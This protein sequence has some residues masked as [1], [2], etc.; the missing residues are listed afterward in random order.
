LTRAIRGP[1]NCGGPGRRPA[2]KGA[3][4]DPPHFG[5]WASVAGIAP[6]LAPESDDRRQVGDSDR[7][8][9]LF[10]DGEW[11]S[12]D[13]LKQ[14]SSFPERWLEELRRDGLWVMEDHLE[15]KVPLGGAGD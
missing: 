6:S 5:G 4:R 3:D 10:A 9:N 2:L 7:V 14:I 12:L 1:E 11:H 8:K 15:H 13:D